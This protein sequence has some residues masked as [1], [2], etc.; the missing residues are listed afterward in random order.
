MVNGKH[1]FQAMRLWLLS[2][3]FVRQA[4]NHFNGLHAGTSPTLWAT[5]YGIRADLY[6]WGRISCALKTGLKRAVPR[7]KK[8]HDVLKRPQKNAPRLVTTSHV[9]YSGSP[10]TSNRICTKPYLNYELR[11]RFLRGWFE[12]RLSVANKKGSTSSTMNYRSISLSNCMYIVLARLILDAMQ[13]PINAAVSESQAK[14]YSTLPQAMNLVLELHKK[15]E[16]NCIYS[17]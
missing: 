2:P 9:C 3:H 11:H 5:R 10:R 7:S 15:S 14:G 1:F 13:Q 17:I 4:H 12:A 16:K 8:D 6:L